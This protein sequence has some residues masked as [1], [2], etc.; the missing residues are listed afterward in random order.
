MKKYYFDSTDNID[1][2]NFLKQ[3]LT[4]TDPL[5]KKMLWFVNKTDYNW[6]KT[7]KKGLGDI[8][9][10]LTKLDPTKERFKNAR[11]ARAF[12][13]GKQIESVYYYRNND[14]HGA[15]DWT[16]AELT[17]TISN[18]FTF[19]IFSCAEYY[20]ELK[21]KLTQHNKGYTQSQ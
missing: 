10:K 5:L 8:F 3:F 16:V 19:Y 15:N 14:T 18:C 12:K 17:K 21:Q 1:K 9:D 7:H 20:S 13:F 4:S 11:T 2:L 6:I